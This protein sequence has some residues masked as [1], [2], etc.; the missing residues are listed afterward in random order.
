MAAADHPGAKRIV[1]VDAEEK[2]KIQGVYM[3]K[4]GVKIFDQ[5]GREFDATP[6]GLYATES[7]HVMVKVDLEAPRWWGDIPHAEVTFRV[8][9]KVEE[10]LP[11]WM[12]E[13]L[14]ERI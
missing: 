8:P 2:I 5:H 14:R 10:R 6:D 1:E 7:E 3:K 4:G 13:Y 11:D 9:L 12:I